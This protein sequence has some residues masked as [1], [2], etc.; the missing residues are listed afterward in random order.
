MMMRYRHDIMMPLP[1]PVSSQKLSL[2]HIHAQCVLWIRRRGLMVGF[3]C[4]L[5]FARHKLYRFY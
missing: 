3:L 5:I 1:P 2:F 4:K